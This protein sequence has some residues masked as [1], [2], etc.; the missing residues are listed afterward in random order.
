MDDKRKMFLKD[1]YDKYGDLP[2]EIFNQ[3]VEYK[4]MQQNKPAKMVLNSEHLGSVLW[5]N[6]RINEIDKEIK[7]LECLYNIETDLE[8]KNYFLYPSY[9]I[10]YKLQELA[11]LKEA[12]RMIINEYVWRRVSE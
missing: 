12:K 8:I 11:S 1:L 2:K 9:Q 3:I 4:T 7:K 10:N 6:K 5:I